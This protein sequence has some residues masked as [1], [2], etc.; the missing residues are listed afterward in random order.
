MLISTCRATS[1]PFCSF[2]FFFVLG[3]LLVW[4]ILC[5]FMA[6]LGLAEALLG[7]IRCILV[8]MRGVYKWSKKALKAAKQ[9]RREKAVD[10]GVDRVVL[11]PCEYPTVDV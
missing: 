7:L 9:Q 11:I 3:C 1:V 8:P 10:A 2:F 5:A 6:G 4:V